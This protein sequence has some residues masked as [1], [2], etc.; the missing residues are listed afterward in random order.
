MCSGFAAK[1]PS[2]W[3]RFR[4]VIFSKLFLMYRIR[5]TICY[6]I[7]AVYIFS[8]E[9][10]FTILNRQLG[11]IIENDCSTRGGKI[12]IA[13]LNSFRWKTFFWLW[14][15]CLC[16]HNYAVLRLLWRRLRDSYCP[17]SKLYNPPL[18]SNTCATGLQ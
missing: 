9:F 11:P 15:L 4:E 13:L 3:V 6:K 2:S 5:F 1:W 10:S 17:W 12:Y 18:K 14:F 8:S 16:E 7:M